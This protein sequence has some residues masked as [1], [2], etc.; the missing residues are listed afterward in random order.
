[1]RLPRLAR[2]GC[3]CLVVSLS[4]AGCGHA[5]SIGAAADSRPT[6]TVG[7]LNAVDCAT[8][9][10]AQDHGYFAAEGLN[11]EFRAI[12]PGTKPLTLLHSGAVTITFDDYL[13]VFG[14]I[15]HGDA[16]HLAADGYQLAPQV[17]PVLAMPGAAIR[18]PRDL[19]GKRIGVPAAGAMQTLL[20]NELVRAYG[21]DPASLRYVPMPYPSMG[22]ALAGGGVD[23]IAP[24]EPF[25]TAA[26]SGYGAQVVADTDTGVTKGVP[27]SGYVSTQAWAAAHPDVLAAFRRAMQRAATDA[28]QRV[29]VEGA[30][31]SHEQIDPRIAAIVHLG[32]FPVSVSAARLGRVVDLMREA[33]TLSRPIDLAALTS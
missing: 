19:A 25:T 28:A 20:I 4:L 1:M 11:V 8:A 15:A 32:A 13:D 17:Q 29:V 30:L 24:V 33:R 6:L 10:I 18:T 5:P 16:L 27:L 14:S 2:I 21:V 3:T 26:E 22:Q 23:A 12:A 31:T 7:V 9:Y